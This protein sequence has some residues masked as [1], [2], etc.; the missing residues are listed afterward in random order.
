MNYEPYT[1]EF[2]SILNDPVFAGILLMIILIG[3][4]YSLIAYLV[5]ALIYFQT[6]KTNNYSDVAYIAWIPFIN[7]YSLFLLSAQDKDDTTNRSN[8]KRNT[9][10]YYGLFIVSFIPVIGFIA[11]I[12]MIGFMLYAMYRL[13]YRWSGE[14]GKA[15]LYI[16]LTFFTAGLFFAVYGLMRMNRPFRAY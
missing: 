6:S 16:I 14:M 4:V 7:V 9:L 12:G 3:L 2:E 10:I 1:N 8:A 5:T 15:I 11:S 13:F